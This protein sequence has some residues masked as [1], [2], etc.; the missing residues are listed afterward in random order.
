MFTHQLDT[1]HFGIQVT[2][3]WWLKR[4]LPEVAMNRAGPIG[5]IA[6]TGLE[7]GRNPKEGAK[8]SIKDAIVDFLDVGTD[9][10]V[11]KIVKG[12]EKLKKMIDKKPKDTEPKE[13]CEDDPDNKKS[14]NT[15]KP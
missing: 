14:L 7:I 4:G 9:G 13:E 6:K 11:G 15:T 10:K 12:L 1:C 3:E 2:Y 8:N 5:K